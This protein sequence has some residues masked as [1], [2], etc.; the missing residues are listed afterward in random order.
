MTSVPATGLGLV[1]ACHP[2][3]TAA[4][5]TL[6]AA[7]AISFGQSAGGT[8]LVAAAVLSGQLSIGW[9]ND[10]LDATRD[11]RVA[12]T[13]K[14]IVT[15]A[16]SA[17]AVG[18]AAGCAVVVCVPLSLAYGWLAG[19]AH[20]VGVGC[21]WAYNAG[22]KRTVWSWVPY[23]L[24]FALLPVFVILGLPEAP[25]P[26]W[27]VPATGALLGVGA[28]V[29]NVVPD[30]DDDLATGV[31][32]GPQRLG[33]V[34]VRIVAPVPLAIASLVLVFG[35]DGPVDAIGWTVLAVTGVLLVLV[36]LPA[37]PRSPRPLVMT[38]AIAALD[39]AFLLYR[40]GGTV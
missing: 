9:S 8:A 13:D 31:R 35:P 3:P 11:R 14:P 25:G 27:W 40:G 7:L 23:A 12:R 38:I 28:H 2:L 37:R 21:G 19:I 26:P 36:V 29:A 18:I 16:V 30:L 34:G 15:G 10:A 17:R 39:V 32:G 33:A 6:A 5:T 4:V 24:A 20:L 1:R 22:L